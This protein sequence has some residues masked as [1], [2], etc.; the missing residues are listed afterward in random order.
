M[1][2]WSLSRLPARANETLPALLLSASKITSRAWAITSSFVNASLGSVVV[3]PSANAKPIVPM[4]AL[5]RCSPSTTC[6]V[7]G[8]TTV[9]LN[10][11]NSPPITI[12][13][14]PR[15]ASSLAARSELVTTVILVQS[16]N[17]RASSKTVLPP[18]R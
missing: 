3:N 17:S 8:P 14:G 2:A 10:R 11:R 15:P 6:R 7:N 4:N 13:R 1:T 16:G 9:W 18:S 12:N 5:S